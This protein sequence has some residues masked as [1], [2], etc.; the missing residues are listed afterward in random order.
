MRRLH[1]L[2][3]ASFGVLAA[4]AAGLMARSGGGAVAT[5]PLTAFLDSTRA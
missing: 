3:L 1:W 2:T 5:S 4:R